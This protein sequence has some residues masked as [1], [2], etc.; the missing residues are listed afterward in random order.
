MQPVNRAIFCLLCFLE[1]ISVLSSNG[2]LL[3]ILSSE[4]AF[5]NPSPYGPFPMGCTDLPVLLISSFTSLC[6]GNGPIS[7]LQAISLSFSIA[8]PNVFI[9]FGQTSTHFPQEVQQYS[10]SSNPSL[11]RSSQSLG[12]NANLEM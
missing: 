7:S 12:S 9:S 4:T 6:T 2:L 3:S 5:I 10:P 1:V 8:A 11:A